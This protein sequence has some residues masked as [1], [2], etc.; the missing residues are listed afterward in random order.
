MEVLIVR[1]KLLFKYQIKE[2]ITAGV[3]ILHKVSYEK[4]IYISLGQKISGNCIFVG[5]N[6]TKL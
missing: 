1:D 6:W 3:L 2:M 5:Y 4:N